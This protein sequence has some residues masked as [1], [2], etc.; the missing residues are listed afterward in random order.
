MKVLL[1]SPLPP[2]LGGIAKWTEKY[3]S[4][5]KD[6]GIDVSVVNIALVGSRSKQINNKKI[7]SDEIVRT[8]RI[9]SDLKAA[10]ATDSFDIVHLNTSCSKFG[11][12][13]DYLC[14]LVVKRK[15]LP[16]VLQCHCDVKNHMRNKVSYFFFRKMVGLSDVVLTLS[17][18]SFEFVNE[19]L[20][21]RAV[22]VPNFVEA[23]M[24]DLDYEVRNELKN[25]VFVGHVN[26]D[27]GCAEILEAAKQLSDC[28]FTFVGPVSLEIAQIKCPDNVE[29]VG[30]KSREEVEHYL[31]NADVFVFPSYSE[32][33]SLALVEAMAVGLPCIVTDVGANK[34]MIENDGGIVISVNN[35][36]ELIDAVNTIRPVE[37]RR[38]MSFWNRKKTKEFYLIDKVAGILFDIYSRLLER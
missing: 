17:S 2:P 26:K 35:E 31:H 36:K 34:D 32:G 23:S 25:A 3:L 14:S 6:N 4:Y 33:F 10:V 38:K 19:I 28:H 9:L 24:L 29:M 11:I 7:I 1:I 20:P 18:R 27:K 21:G 30:E 13:R 16:L 8:K 5:C 37:I 15:K 22:M 12:V